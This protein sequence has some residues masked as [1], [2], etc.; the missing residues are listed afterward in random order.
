MS[1]PTVRSCVVCA[2]ENPEHQLPVWASAFRLELCT[3]CKEDWEKSVAYSKLQFMVHLEMV[4][5]INFKRCSLPGAWTKH[6][7][8]T[9]EHF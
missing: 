8:F 4:A 2:A 3:R 9:L 1:S 5:Y 6:N 7:T